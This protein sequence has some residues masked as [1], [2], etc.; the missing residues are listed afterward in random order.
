MHAGSSA[1]GAHL[2]TSVRNLE[3]LRDQHLRVAACMDALI[4]TQGFAASE[5]FLDLQDASE[6]LECAGTVTHQINLMVYALAAR[7]PTV[8]GSG[9]QEG[10]VLEGSIR[11]EISQHENVTTYQVTLPTSEADRFLAASHEMHRRFATFGATLSWNWTVPSA[12]GPYDRGNTLQLAL[13]ISFA[14][15]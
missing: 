15:N 4:S 8:D 13:L 6:K 7:I 12:P 1:P 9:W 14:T 3:H 10:F 5:V 2:D 11:A